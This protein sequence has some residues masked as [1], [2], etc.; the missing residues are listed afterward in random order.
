MTIHILTESTFDAA[1]L[2]TVLTEDDLRE[3][4]IRAVDGQS[5]IYSVARTFLAVR[6]EPV[7]VVIDAE[8]SDP[9]AVSRRR[10]AAEEVIGDVASGVPYRVIVAVPEMLVL[11]FRRPELLRRVF[12]NVVTDHLLELAE[13]DPR[14]ALRKLDPSAADDELRFR[15]LQAMDRDDTDALQR[16]DL[17][18]ELTT[19]LRS[20]R[21]RAEEAATA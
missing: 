17:I 19:F 8:S 11:L 3:A 2:A 6:Q 9:R 5:S 15:V 12:G 14:K 7:A 20:T 10:D 1:L 13:A 21:R 18:Q 4:S 16:S